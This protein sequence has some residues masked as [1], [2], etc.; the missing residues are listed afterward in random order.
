MAI[1]QFSTKGQ[2]VIPVQIRRKYGLRPGSK[3]EVLDVEDLIVLCP[4]P[5]DPI[6]AAEGFLT[7]KN[8]V[9]EKVGEA[10]SEEKGFEERTIK[11][12][13]GK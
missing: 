8:T 1:A 4:L 6:E 7:S 11:R 3:V 2:I 10:R 5:E 13:P 9:L 12:F